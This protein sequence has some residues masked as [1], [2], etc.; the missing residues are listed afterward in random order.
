[1]AASRK[2]RGVE[3][4]SK[5]QASSMQRNG[6]AASAAANGVRWRRLALSVS[7]RSELFKAWCEYQPA[8]K[9]KAPRKIK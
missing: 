6:M 7:W 3:E 1:M 4:N 5:H 8:K 2:S 9:R